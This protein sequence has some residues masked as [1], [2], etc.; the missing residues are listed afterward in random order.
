MPSHKGYLIL[1][2]GPSGAGKDS[3]IAGAQKATSNLKHIKFVR[4]YITRPAD[5][6]GEDHISLSEDR[7]DAM[8]RDQAFCLHWQAHGLR[9]GISRDIVDEVDAGRS[10]IAN[11]SRTIIDEARGVFPYVGVLNVTAPAA[12]IAGRLSARGRESAGEIARRLDRTVPVIGSEVVDLVN[13]QTLE[14]GVRRFV[15]I[16]GEFADRAC[17][18]DNFRTVT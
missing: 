8:V 1:V 13:D 10:V 14:D 11:V 17:L 6:G 12:I 4:R 16:V 2:V 9:Y 18:A 5:T 7:F 15:D 3:L